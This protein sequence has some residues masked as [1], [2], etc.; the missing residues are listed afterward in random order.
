MRLKIGRLIQNDPFAF[1][2]SIKVG[3]VWESS[4]DEKGDGAV[5][6]GDQELHQV[7]RAEP[8]VCEGAV[9]EGGALQDQWRAGLGNGGFQ[10]SP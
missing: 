4:S 1:S 6:G 3:A 8:H 2:H 5:G 9:E 10:Q 7:P